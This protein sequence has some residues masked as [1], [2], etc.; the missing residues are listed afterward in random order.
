MILVPDFSPEQSKARTLQDLFNQA[1]R[2]Q[3][4]QNAKSATIDDTCL[5]RMAVGDERVLMCAAGSFIPDSKVG[6]CENKG[7]VVYPQR[8]KN[9]AA[10]FWLTYYT[11]KQRL[12][13]VSL[14]L[15]HDYASGFGGGFWLT[16][17]PRFEDVAF[18]F[19]LTCPED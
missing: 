13:L 11:E 2:V 8:S 18:K 4:E 9:E 1:W 6:V 10:T 5:Y 14:Q 7:V 17:R 15:Q 12:L 19:G 3:K 16:L